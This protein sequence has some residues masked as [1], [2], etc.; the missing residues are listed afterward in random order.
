[1]SRFYGFDKYQIG[2]I[3]LIDSPESLA[4]FARTWKRHHPLHP[5]QFAFAGQTAKIANSLL[6]HGGDI[7]YELEGIPGL[8]HQQLLSPL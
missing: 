8:W 7:L 4:A 1:M 6:Y 3:V 5:R 2:E